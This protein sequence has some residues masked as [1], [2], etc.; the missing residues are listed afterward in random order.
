MEIKDLIGKKVNN[1]LWISLQ[2]DYPGLKDKKFHEIQDAKL[3]EEDDSIAMVK[4]SPDSIMELV[5]TDEW[6]DDNGNILDEEHL[7]VPFELDGLELL[8]FPKEE[9][10]DGTFEMLGE[11]VDFQSATVPKAA[12]AHL[13]EFV[14][15]LRKDEAL[16][17]MYDVELMKIQFDED[18]ELT[19]KEIM[20][21]ERSM[22]LNND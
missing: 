19:V 3:Y 15:E 1:L 8:N 9:E 11:N 16:K 18:Q 17:E 22:D 6:F 12:M 5:N 14:K 20:S 21:Y 2:M 10:S 7:W 13:I 4:L